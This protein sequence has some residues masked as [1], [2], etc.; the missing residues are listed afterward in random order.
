MQ[1]EENPF[2]SPFTEPARQRLM[3]S[4]VVTHHEPGETLFEEH[5]PPDAVFL[6][7]SGTIALTKRAREHTETLAEVH[8]GEYFGEMGVIDNLGRSAAA[9][10]KTEACVARIPGPLLMEVLRAEPSA[11]SL[12]FVHRVSDYLR[13]T[14][15][16]FM[17]QV[18]HKERMQVVGEMAS[19]IIH[20]FK[21]P[22]T[23]IQLGIEMIDQASE[24]PATEHYCT[25]ILGQLNRMVAMA[26]ELL[27]YSR[28]S[29]DL[30]RERVTVEQFLHEFQV[31]NEDFLTRSR[32]TLTLHS[33]DTE[34]DID[35]T[36]FMRV[37]QNILSNAV[38]AF[39]NGEGSVTIHASLEDDTMVRFDIADSGPG[40]PEPIRSRVFEPFVTYGKRKG[41]GLGMAIARTIVEA[42]GGSILFSTETGKGTTFTITI[43]RPQSP[44]L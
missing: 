43:P 14:N 31:Y 39:G 42:H 2:F 24:N 7:L 1:L 10:A 19:S 8:S 12:H 6:V 5:D 3:D 23:S 32:V 22:I 4:V 44:G 26:E 18:L 38:E 27:A 33:A 17:A 25:L 21:N 30:Q 9:C 16:R 37:F 35:R 36:R 15:A 28:G 20:D 11:A 13:T 41:T 29:T 40:I 34:I